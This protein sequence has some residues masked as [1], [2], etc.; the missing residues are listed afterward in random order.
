LPGPAFFLP[1]IVNKT[2]MYVSSAPSES[3]RALEFKTETLPGP[4]VW[5]C[6]VCGHDYNAEVDGGGAAFEDLPDTWLCP[7]CGEPKSVYYKPPAAPN[8]RFTAAVP[9]DVVAPFLLE[10]YVPFG[11]FDGEGHTPVHNL[12]YHTAV[13][14]VKS[15]D[16]WNLIEQLAQNL[17]E[18]TIRDLRG[19][20]ANSVQAVV[21]LNGTHLLGK[22][23]VT[24]F[25]GETGGRLG[26]F[27]TSGGIATLDIPEGKRVFAT[28]KYV[29]NTPGFIDGALYA[30]VEHWAS[31]SAVLVGEVSV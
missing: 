25:D 16:D 12:I 6:T 5:T 10:S 17:F 4:P 14:V 11:L 22:T 21:R 19:T 27:E 3:R 20:D 24:T 18:I 26:V 23:N 13:P 2:S 7:V 29:D 30:Y 31:T 15:P 1:M 9:T 28:A 8:A